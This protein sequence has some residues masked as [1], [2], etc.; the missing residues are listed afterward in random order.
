LNRDIYINIKLMEAIIQPLFAQ[1]MNIYIYTMVKNSFVLNLIL[2]FQVLKLQFL[3]KKQM[4]LEVSIHYFLG[5]EMYT[6][7]K[8]Q[9]AV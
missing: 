1:I 5:M 4:R 3:N 9:L 6:T 8:F 7:R 2:K